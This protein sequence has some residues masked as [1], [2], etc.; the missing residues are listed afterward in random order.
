M[1]FTNPHSYRWMIGRMVRLHCAGITHSGRLLAVKDDYLALL[2]SDQCLY[3]QTHQVKSIAVESIHNLPIYSSRNPHYSYIMDADKFTDLLRKMMYR[4]VLI[5][6]NGPEN[7]RGILAK[8]FHDHVDLIYDYELIRVSIPHIKCICHDISMKHSFAT[9]SS[10]NNEKTH[11]S[12]KENDTHTSEEL[13]HGNQA[14]SDKELPAPIQAIS[15]PKVETP[16]TLSEPTCTPP[17]ITLPPLNILP[18]LAVPLTKKTKDMQHNVISLPEE[19]K[20]DTLSPVESDQVQFSKAMNV[21]THSKAYSPVKKSPV[22][23]RKATNKKNVFKSPSPIQKSS[24]RTSMPSKNTIRKNTANKQWNIVSTRKNKRLN[25][26]GSNVFVTHN[27][28]LYN[29]NRFSMV[30]LAP[31]ISCGR[32]YRKLERRANK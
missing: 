1:K 32:L 13:T 12:K 19:N 16:R 8:L 29:R 20:N 7:M 21:S 15:E 11:S 6:Q 18:S 14:T 24:R 31:V 17:K 27:W 3:F 5:N 4:A 28:H 23:Q 30:W 2:S 25:K 9:T 10:N 22:N 26:L